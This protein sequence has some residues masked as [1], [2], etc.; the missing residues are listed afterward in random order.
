MDVARFDA[1]FVLNFKTQHHETDN[2]ASA[3]TKQTAGNGKTDASA[4]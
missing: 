3:E 4:A 2:T 1:N